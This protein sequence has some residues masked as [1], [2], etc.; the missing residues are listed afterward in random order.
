MKYDWP[1]W[2]LMHA[3][4]DAMPVVFRYGDVRDVYK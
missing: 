4:A 1:V 3:C 2:Q